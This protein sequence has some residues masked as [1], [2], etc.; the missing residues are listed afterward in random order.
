VAPEPYEAH[1]SA[2]MT[3]QTTTTTETAT[4]EATATA[5]SPPPPPFRN[6]PPVTERELAARARGLSSA[7]IDGGDDPELEHTKHH[8]ARYMRLLVGMI[9]LIVGVSIVVTIVGLAVAGGGQ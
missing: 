5:P 1:D 6:L 3:D 2:T 4:P 9:V 8:E 7:Y